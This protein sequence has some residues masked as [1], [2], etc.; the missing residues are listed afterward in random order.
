MAYCQEAR[1]VKP[2]KSHGLKRISL[3]DKPKS[4]ITN[5]EVVKG[6]WNV[7]II[8]LFPDAFPGVLGLSLTGK[9]LQC[10]SWTLSTIDLRDFGIGKHNKVDDTPSGGGPGLVIR[11]DVLGPAIETALSRAESSTRLVYLSP[12]GKTFNQQLAR[13]WSKSEGIILIC[14]RFEGIDQRVIDHYGIEEVSMGDFVMTGGEIAAQAMIDTT[15]RLLP[16]VIGNRDSLKTESHS[17][18]LIEH[19]QFT[20]PNEWKGQKIPQTLTSGHHGKI[21]SWRENQ[22][23]SKTKR[24]RADLW[25]KA[26]L[27]K[28]KS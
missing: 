27:A 17:N 12:R 11:A 15:V 21:E 25:E 9:A 6:A 7:Q 1:M 8:T 14:G 5:N 19:D 28:G 22:S 23:K 16:N 3:S 2:A 18:G 20:R 24:Y 26:D 13:K 4:L 10:R